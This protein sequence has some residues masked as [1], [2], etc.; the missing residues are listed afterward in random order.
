MVEN[1]TVGG[2]FHE[3]KNIIIFVLLACNGDAYRVF[4]LEK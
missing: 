4:R 2:N 1:I 3:E